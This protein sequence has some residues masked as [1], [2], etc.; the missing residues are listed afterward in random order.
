M[1]A[2]STRRYQH[3]VRSDAYLPNPQHLTEAYGD[4]H[5]QKMV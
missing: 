4:M 5:F 3:A 2:L 1:E